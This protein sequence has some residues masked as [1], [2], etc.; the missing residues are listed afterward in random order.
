[1]RRDEGDVL[2]CDVPQRQ[3]WLPS[4]PLIMSWTSS[5]APRSRD[6]DAGKP[7]RRG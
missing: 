4:L 1:M 6:E 5:I 3:D 7:S 2:S